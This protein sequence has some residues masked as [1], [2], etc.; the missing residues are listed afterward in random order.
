M[1]GLSGIIVGK[2]VRNDEQRDR[3]KQIFTQLLRY[4]EHRG[5][6]ATGV[7]LIQSDGNC[8][9]KKAPIPAMDFVRTPEYEEAISNL[10]DD[11]TLI[12][13]H[14]RWPTV[15][16]H[17]NN[18]NNQ[19]LLSHVNPRV[20]L[21]H[22]GHIGNYR[23]LFDRYNFQRFTQVDSEI[24]LRFAERNI[25]FDGIQPEWLIRD[26]K[27]CLGR[28]SVVIVATRFPYKILLVKGNQPLQMRYNS[29]LFIFA[30]ASENEILDRVIGSE[31]D[32]EP[33]NMPEWHL[34][35]V[36]TQTLL[37]LISYPLGMRGD[38]L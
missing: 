32:W 16:S 9:L 3:I 27:E 38:E 2:H 1:C 15:G 17:H 24:L 21:S 10:D 22:N 28:L 34:V 30:Y 6:F 7:A 13:G 35:T 25:G 14:T 8:F 20:L 26:L 4:S 36:N 18:E 12:M 11:T 33:I 23:A 37:P 19:P 31:E 5:P 29:E